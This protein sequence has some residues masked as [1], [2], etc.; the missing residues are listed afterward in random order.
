MSSFWNGERYDVVIGG[1]RID[2]DARLLWM[3]G[4][5]ILQRGCTQGKCRTFDDDVC[6]RKTTL[7]S[8]REGRTMRR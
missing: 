7:L 4:T 3:H 5:E 8:V 2:M 6:M 1:V